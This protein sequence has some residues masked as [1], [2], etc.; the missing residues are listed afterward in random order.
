[1]QSPGPVFHCHDLFNRQLLL[2]SSAKLYKTW[3][4]SYLHKDFQIHSRAE[5][6]LPEVNEKHLNTVLLKCTYIL[7]VDL[8]SKV[9]LYKDYLIYIS[10]NNRGHK[11]SIETLK[12]LFSSNIKYCIWHPLNMILYLNLPSVVILLL[13]HLKKTWHRFIV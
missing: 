1:M 10:R 13:V 11:F 5:L 7:H 12:I 4:R 6:W 9:N 2:H 8:S 3:Q